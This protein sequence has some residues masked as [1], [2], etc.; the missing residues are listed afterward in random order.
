MFIKQN[1]CNQTF[2]ENSE[3]I[4][5]VSWYKETGGDGSSTISS[6][7]RYFLFLRKFDF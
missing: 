5:E 6:N 2:V 3:T 4:N 1:S 7:S